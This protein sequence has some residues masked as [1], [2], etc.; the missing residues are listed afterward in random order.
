VGEF[1][2]KRPLGRPRHRWEDNIKVNLQEMGWGGMDGLGLAENRDSWWTVVNAM[3]NLWVPYNAGNFLTSLGPVSFARRTLLHG[4]LAC[5]KV[6]GFH[7]ELMARHSVP[8][9]SWPCVA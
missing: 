4:E 1:D 7:S 6:L 3:M 8:G 5:H 9:S 2:G